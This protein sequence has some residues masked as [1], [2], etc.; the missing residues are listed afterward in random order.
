MISMA[1]SYY[2][3]NERS[4]S[5]ELAKW[6]TSQTSEVQRANS[7]MINCYIILYRRRGL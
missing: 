3:C 5:N 2:S 4:F 7:Q 6:L 1:P